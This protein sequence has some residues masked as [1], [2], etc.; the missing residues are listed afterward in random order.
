M[1]VGHERLYP[2]ERAMG[3]KPEAKTWK[4]R[5]GGSVGVHGVRVLLLE[6]PTGRK[7]S[8]VPL[9]GV[10]SFIALLMALRR[11]GGRADDAH[12]KTTRGNRVVRSRITR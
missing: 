12:K 8:V 10:Q 5:K 3:V 4:V 11:G 1:V 7:G 2:C 9:V 6:K